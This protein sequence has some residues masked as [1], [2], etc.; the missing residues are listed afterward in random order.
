EAGEGGPALEHVVDGAGDV[1]VPRQLAPLL[2]HPG[3]QCGNE[4]CAA[5]LAH[6]QTLL[7]WR[8]IDGALDV[9]QD[10]DALHRFQRHRR[11]RLRCGARGLAA[12][13]RL[14]VGE[15]EEPA[16]RMGP[17]RRFENRC[18]TSPGLVEL[19]IAAEGIGLQDAAPTGQVLP[20]MFAGA[21]ARVKE[22]RRW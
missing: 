4:W 5:L 20:G 16:P 10:V 17:T 22:Q 18:W 12:Y 11:D 2:A 13:R 8:T 15:L 6:R 3:F 21:V 14:K 9:E 1:A 7:G 19:A